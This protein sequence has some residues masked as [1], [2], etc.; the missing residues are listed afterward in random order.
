MQLEVCRICEGR[1]SKNEILVPLTPKTRGKRYEYLCKK[2]EDEVL[3]KL[4]DHKVINTDG[5]WKKKK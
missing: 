2:C 5:S 1:I 3:K 4:A